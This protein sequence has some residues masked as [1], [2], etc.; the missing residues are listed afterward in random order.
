MWARGN[1]CVYGLIHF[2][3]AKTRTVAVPLQWNGC[4][5][6]I[7]HLDYYCSTIMLIYNRDD[8]Q[9]IDDLH[10]RQ[11]SIAIMCFHHETTHF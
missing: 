2:Q 7:R 8:T 5:G 6:C 3:S 10:R 4:V 11:Y 9:M 1:V